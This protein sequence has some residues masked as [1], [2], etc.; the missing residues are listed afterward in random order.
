[1]ELND[2][3]SF[4]KEQMHGL[5]VAPSSGVKKALFGKMFFRNLVLFHKTKLIVGACLLGTGS[6]ATYMALNADQGEGQAKIAELNNTENLSTQTQSSEVSLTAVSE[7]DE[8]SDAYKSAD[9][10][11]GGDAGAGSFEDNDLTAGTDAG[12]GMAT[13]SSSFETSSGSADK[14]SYKSQ[15]SDNGSASAEVAFNSSDAGA[16]NQVRIRPILSQ[17]FLKPEILY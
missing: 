8:Y 5:E 7:S 10:N 2:F 15:S 16:L 13:M 12:A 1:M 3:D 6:V 17:M 4:V 14:F 9:Q 11:A